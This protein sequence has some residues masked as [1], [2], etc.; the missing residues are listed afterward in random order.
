M[1]LAVLLLALGALLLWG[2]RGPSIADGSLLVVDVEGEYLEASS[3]PLAARLLGAERR[4]LAALLSE[5]AKAERD[6]RIDTVVFRIRPLGIGWAKAQE[7]RNAMRRVGE[8]ERRTVAYLE[9][10]SFAANLEYYV[11][12]GAEEIRVAPGSLGPVLGLAAEYL[13][14]GALFEKLGV[15][16][17]YER[18]GEYKS[19]VETFAEEKM[20]TAAREMA[21]SLLDSI[22][23]QFVAGI[24]ESRELPTS[25]VREAIDHAPGA[26]AELLERGF[27]DEVGTFQEL[28]EERGEP[29]LVTQEE[30]AG[31]PLEDV[32][33]APQKRIALIYGSGMVVVGDGDVSPRGSLVAASTTL[34]RALDDASEDP[35]IAAIVLRVDSPGG[36]ALASDIVWRA[37]RRARG[38]GKPLVASFSDVAASGGYYFSSIADRIVAEP[39][40]ITGS[41]GVFVLRPVLGDL[42]AR[43]GVGVAVLTRGAHADLQLA[44]KPLSP[45]TRRRLRALV[46]EAYGTFLARVSEGRELPKERVDALGRG[47]VYTGEQAADAGLVDVLG[48]LREAVD[49]AKREAGIDPEADVELVPY[50][51]PRPLAEQLTELLG[52]SVRA[53]ELRE[54]LPA[55]LGSVAE[56]LLELPSGAPVL[57]PP[58]FPTIR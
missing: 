38:R 19:A 1:L 10:E 25:V 14:F 27:V 31:V 18:V 43:L 2:D 29:P 20:S 21:N 23:T 35:E 55:R 44:S 57:V 42:F 17:E 47:R 46:Q 7:I 3:A 30:Y 24:A 41:I 5:L 11:A 13:F 45:G 15:D 8:G 52:A 48:G 12:T 50:P 36:S 40:S 37:A 33:F 34:A 54:L 49:E 6:D 28:L 32:G 22:E 56:L 39:A 4:P 16:V 26:P 53:G 9:L 58:L 51:P